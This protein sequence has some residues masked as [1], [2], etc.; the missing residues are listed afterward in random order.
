MYPAAWTACRRR[1]RRCTTISATRRF[2]RRPCKRILLCVGAGLP[3]I[4]A[5]R[6]NCRTELLVSRASQLPPKTVFI[7]G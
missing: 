6:F 7:V 3:A 5:P 1:G 2:S 4:A